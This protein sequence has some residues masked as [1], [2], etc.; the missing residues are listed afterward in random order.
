M[1]QNPPACSGV[2]WII[3]GFTKA[4]RTGRIKWALTI[5]FSSVSSFP[6]P[7]WLGQKDPCVGWGG[8]TLWASIWL[9]HTLAFSLPF[10]HCLGNSYSHLALHMNSYS[11]RCN[12]VWEGD[13]KSNTWLCWRAF[14]ASYAYSPN[15]PAVTKRIGRCVTTTKSDNKK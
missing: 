10:R 4:V 14:G 9:Y 13:S 7:L 6:S 11:S 8:G 1:P 5:L 2:L 12:A 15:S 3:N